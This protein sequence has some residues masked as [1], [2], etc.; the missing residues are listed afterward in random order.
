VVGFGLGYWVGS[1]WHGGHYY[2]GWHG[3]WH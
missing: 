3:H 1:A 2:G